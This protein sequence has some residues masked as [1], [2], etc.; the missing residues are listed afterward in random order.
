[1]SLLKL[2]VKKD[3]AVKPRNKD[4]YETADGSINVTRQTLYRPELMFNENGENLE[5]IEIRRILY[6]RKS[7]QLTIDIQLVLCDGIFLNFQQLKDRL[8]RPAS[9]SPRNVQEAAAKAATM[10]EFEQHSPLD[11]SASDTIDESLQEKLERVTNVSRA[12]IVAREKSLNDKYPSVLAPIL[13][14]FLVKY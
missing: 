2:K 13:I 9:I 7:D 10:H 6:Y 1:M 5:R 12:T 4:I 3:Q 14:E 8:P 11:D